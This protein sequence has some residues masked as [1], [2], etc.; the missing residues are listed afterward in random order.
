MMIKE[1]KKYNV[2][3][4]FTGDDCV[5]WF[6]VVDEYCYLVHDEQ[7]DEEYILDYEEILASFIFE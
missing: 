3:D 7:Y 5:I 1:N 4:S 2:K 6:E